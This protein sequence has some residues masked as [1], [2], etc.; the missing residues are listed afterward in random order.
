MTRP[1]W[2]P[3]GR[4]HMVKTTDEGDV[5]SVAGQ[6]AE[7]GTRDFLLRL[8]ATIRALRRQQGL[9]Q[10]QLGARA[11]IQGSR[12]GEIERGAVNTSITRVRSI[13]SGL[14]VPASA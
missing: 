13:A 4:D 6:D 9:R 5:G 3:E 2:R 14:G 11:G 7:V 12:I 10:G 8:G 1:R